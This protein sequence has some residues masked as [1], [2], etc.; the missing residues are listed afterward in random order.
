MMKSTK[1]TSILLL[2]FFLAP[3]FAPLAHS[4]SSA[5]NNGEEESHYC[6]I[7]KGPCKHGE[8][9]PR[10]DQ[11]HKDKH[12]EHDKEHNTEHAQKKKESIQ[13]NSYLASQCHEGESSLFHASFHFTS[14]TITTTELMPG[15]N[16]IAQMLIFDNPTIYKNT[17][18]ERLDR[19]PRKPL[20]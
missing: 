13:N 3:W 17:N 15:I 7:S 6:E 5:D 14:F 16:D 9:C 19:P 11:H 12:S 20:S 18:L 1:I 8:A 2:I 10:K 4:F